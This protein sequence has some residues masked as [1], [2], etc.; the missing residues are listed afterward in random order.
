MRNGSTTE[1]KAFAETKNAQYMVI[2]GNPNEMNDDD[3]GDTTIC[4]WNSVAVKGAVLALIAAMIFTTTD[5][6]L[7]PH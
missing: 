3:G 4:V 6:G 5:A 2:F 7:E 1:L